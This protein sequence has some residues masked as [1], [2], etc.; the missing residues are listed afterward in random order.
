MRENASY[1]GQAGAGVLF[2]CLED[3]T[4]L[5]MKRSPYVEQPNTW[6]IPGGSIKGEE[7]FASEESHAGPPSNGV[8]WAG[9]VREVIE[10][11][12]SVPVFKYLNF[13]DYVDGSFIY[14]NFV[15]DISKET[16]RDWAIKLNWENTEYAWFKIEDL[17]DNLHFGVVYLLDTL[18]L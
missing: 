3:N 4:L 11:C 16:K 12:G 15:L 1:W 6:G 8:F 2:V 13:V 7:M 5:L 17:P 9:V 10:E 18:G 14:R